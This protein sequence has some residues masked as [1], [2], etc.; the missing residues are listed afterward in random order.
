VFASRKLVTALTMT[1]LTASGCS[2][3]GTGSRLQ[4]A[5][6]PPTAAPTVAPTTGP[7]PSTAP[8]HPAVVDGEPWI[9]YETAYTSAGVDGASVFLVRPDIPEEPHQLVTIHAEHPDWSRDGRRIAFVAEPTA[10]SSEIWALHPDGSGKQTLVACVETPCVGFAAPAWSPDGKQLVFQRYLQPTAKGYEDDQIAI[11]VLDIASGKTRVVALSPVVAGGTY[12][13]YVYP[14]WSPDGTQIVFA[15]H[16]YPTPPT[17]ENIRS[18]TIAVV[19]ADG[20]EVDAPQ[21]LTDPALFGSYPD[22]SPDGQRI[23]FNTYPIG[24][25]Q[26]TT[27]AQN[28]Y[29]IRPDGTGLTQL[30]HFGENDARAVEPTW[31][32]DG[33]RIIFVHI[34]RSAN[35]PQGVRK[36]AF[37]DADGSN[38][39]VLEWFGTHPRL[40]PV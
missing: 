37:V 23:V 18:S 39:T 2:A 21:I 15:V 12:V 16:T 34:A 36:I 14:R 30:T 26:D 13:E 25:F 17:D 22:W 4:T 19:K 1:L 9:V 5:S 8:T 28:L 3:S 20:S 38:L 33:K 10:D 35:D 11:E 24:S 40:R 7:A 31:T 32:P 27:K 6:L 29:T